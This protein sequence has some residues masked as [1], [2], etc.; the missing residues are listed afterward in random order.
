MS[1]WPQIASDSGSAN[2]AWASDSPSG[3][4]NRFLS[5]MWGID[6]PLGVGARVV[7]AHQLAVEAEVLVA[8]AAQP[9][10]AAPQRRD[11][12]HVVA[13]RDAAS[14]LTSR[15]AARADLDHLAADLVAEHPRRRDPAVA[16]VER[17]HVGAAD[18]ARGDAQQDAVLGADGI[19]H[20]ADL[21]APGPVPD[22]CAHATPPRFTFGSVGAVA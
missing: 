20:V 6:D 18:P 2:V 10:A 13:D 19:R 15:S 7:E 12:V 16:V 5:A 17:A 21:H 14:R 4:R 22:R 11:A 8:A 9:A 3:I 1:L